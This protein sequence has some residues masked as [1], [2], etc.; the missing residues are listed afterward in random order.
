MASTVY[1]LNDIGDIESDRKHK[2]KK[3]RPLAS[4]AISKK[5]AY[6]VAI[7]LVVLSILLSSI[8]SILS[9]V[10]VISYLI[11]NIFYTLYLKRVVIID[12][13]IISFG[14]MLRILAGTVGLGIEPSEW[15]LLCGLML[16][17]FLGFC[18]RWSEL[19]TMS[20]MIIQDGSSI[21]RAVLKDYKL[22]TL[23]QFIS[24][25]AAA[26]II[27]YGLY[28]VSDKTI[29]IHNTG[30]LI[31]TLPFVIYGIFRY[32][33]LL[34]KENSGNDTAKDI[35]KDWHLLINSFLWLV[36]T[37]WILYHG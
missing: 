21:T 14:F 33:Y 37:F 31:Y 19:N 20:P 36:L 6:V 1:I 18:K 29:E 35:L 22:E 32:I 8:V 28:T 10:L 27:S 3:N 24:I 2:T 30:Y 15:L 13:F 5:T 16:T 11:I 34:H 25:T 17:L 4:G 7:I 26:V 23:D 12:V 9:L